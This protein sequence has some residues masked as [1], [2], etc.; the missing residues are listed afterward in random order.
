MVDVPEE[1]WVVAYSDLEGWFEETLPQLGLN[2][3]EAAQFIE[4]WM[5]ELPEV[6]YYEMRLLTDEYL[7]QNMQLHVVPEPDTVIRLMV[8][9]TPTNQKTNLI[10][11]K[12]TTPVREGFVVS[13][14]GGILDK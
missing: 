8:H 2:E 6:P 14:W 5:E 9:F 10:E 11:P 1:G 7:A 13:E 4:Y 12:I 3:K